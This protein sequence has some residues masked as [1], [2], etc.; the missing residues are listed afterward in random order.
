M[1][2]AGPPPWKCHLPARWGLQEV[3]ESFERRNSIRFNWVMRV[4]ADT[5]WLAPVGPLSTLDPTLAYLGQGG[6]L[7]ALLLFSDQ[8]V[9][10][11]QC[12][13]NVPL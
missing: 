11:S 10:V 2:P 13:I 7:I 9:P 1:P 3:V 5:K 12:R 4:R 8:V 6:K